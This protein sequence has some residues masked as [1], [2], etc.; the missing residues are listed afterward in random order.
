[1]TLLSIVFGMLITIGQSIVY[2]MTGMYG[3]P[4]E[5]G[6][7]VCLVIILQVC[8]WWESVSSCIATTQTHSWSLYIPLVFLSSSSLTHLFSLSPFFLP[9]PFSPSHSPPPYLPLLLLIFLSSFLTS[10][11][12]F[13]SSYLPFSS[14]LLSSFPLYPPHLSSSPSAPLCWSG[15][16]VTR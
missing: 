7:G 2:V 3:P 11:P 6:A 16:L 1:M 13:L 5:L 10:S 14:S 12:S 15:C 9:I 8:V 4:S